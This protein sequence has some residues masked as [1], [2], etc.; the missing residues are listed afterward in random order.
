MKKDDDLPKEAYVIDDSKTLKPPYEPLANPPK[1]T[2][3]VSIE[4]ARKKRDAKR[5]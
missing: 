5:K 3:V 4:E 1:T 2:K